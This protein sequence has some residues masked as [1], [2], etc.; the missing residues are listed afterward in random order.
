MRLCRS[1]RGWLAI[2]SVT[3]AL[4]PGH[5]GAAAAPVESFED[6]IPAHVT[7]SRPGSLSLS[8]EHSKH[9]ERSLRW[10]WQAGDRV[11]FRQGLGDIHRQGGYGGSY[12]KATFGF[13]LYNLEPRPESFTVE[14]RAGEKPGGRF[15]FPVDFSGWRH[16]H[17]RLTWQSQLE[18]AVSPATDRVLVLAPPQ[19]AGVV[20][21]DLLVY[22]GLLDYR[23][24]YVPGSQ[25]Y[26]PPAPDPILHPLPPA[27]SAEEDA[28][29]KLV[30][31]RLDAEARGG[32]AVTSAVMDELAAALAHW[33][34]DRNPDGSIRG[35]PVVRNPELYAEFALDG[36]VGPAEPSRLLLRL[37]QAH[38]NSTDPAQ[39]ARLAEWYMRLADHLHDQGLAAGAGFTWNWYG[40]RDLA[41]ATFLMRRALRTAGRLEREA[42]YFDSNY[43]F[44]RIFADRTI[45]PTM[46]YFHNDVRNIMRGCV[47]QPSQPEAIQALRALSRRLSLDILRQGRDGFR[48]D[49]SAFH[50]GMHYHAYANYGTDTLC[51]L[52]RH[53]GGTPFQVNPE[54]LARVKQVGLNMRFYCNESDLPLSLCGRHPHSQGVSA[55]KF[56][57]LAFALES[58]TGIDRELAAAY[59]RLAPTQATEEPF[60]ALG[61]Q[62][63]PTPH[64]LLSMPHAGLLAVRR[65]HWLAV[66][67]GYSRYVHFGEIYA[68]NNR[69]GRYLSNGYLDILAGGQPVTRKDSGC[70]P[71]GWDW[72]RLDG[73]TVI[74]LEPARLRAVSRG[75]EFIGTD[76]A[77]CGAA[78]GTAGNATFALRLHGAQQHDSSFRAR[79]SY[80]WFDRLGAFVCLGSGITAA[81]REHPVQTTLFQQALPSLD[82][83]TSVDGTPR[84]GLGEPATPDAT[85]WH[86]LLDTQ[87]TAYVVPPGQALT[88]VRRHQANPDHTDKRIT[89]G[90]FACAWLDHGR[91]PAAATYQY[92]VMPA[93]T[94][95]G[96]AALAQR[97]AD[98]ARAPCQIV[99]LDQAAHVVRG[100][101]EAGATLSAVFF[102]P[103]Q[104]QTNDPVLRALTSDRPGIVVAERTG[105][106]VT[107]SLTD[108]DLRLGADC[109]S[110]PAQ[111]VLR[112]A[113]RWRAEATEPGRVSASAPEDDA[114]AVTL[115]C[116]GGMPA[117]IVLRRSE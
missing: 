102:E 114:T 36:I 7:P 98:T 107:L 67:K 95:A 48:P 88:L 22:N 33:A 86:W 3:L 108:P 46:D 54:A 65:G 20:F 37:A 75:T 17:L 58:S 28:A 12:S 111:T 104:V 64:G 70:T 110:Q 44:S 99:R 103:G 113:G 100:P 90:D 89:E 35:R 2:A 39:Q 30:E 112:L 42:A 106:R 27:V 19:G 83:P 16:A 41:S 5:P 40:G 91:A 105:N 62:P 8:S 15:R 52:L 50:H 116:S 63:E 101:H 53:L 93:C 59:L 69:Y 85:Q 72:N 76:E 87:G 68:D 66:V 14:L 84:T 80:H 34:L 11:E 82:T 32:I 38:A 23:Q 31:Q 51:A 1:R 109:V 10:D 73:T 74:L 24:P 4:A 92:V 71:D 9:G 115:T 29:L 79:K 21:V 45:G 43:G 25:P 96:A 97:V 26:R 61:L 117:R 47:M 6:A 13:W 56:L 77:F 78:T 57:N 81:D 55:A 49:G 18:G 94:A 60:R